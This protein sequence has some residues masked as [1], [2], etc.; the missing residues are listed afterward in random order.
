MSPRRKKTRWCSCPFEDFRGEIFKPRATPMSELEIVTLYQ[1]ELEAVKLC[2][3][4]GLTQEEAG[5][6]MGVSRGTVQRLI[7]TAH[8][9]IADAIVNQKALTFK[10]Y[11]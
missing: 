5:K 11:K 8:R 6:R 2:D 3:L 9:K 10:D 4:E 1:D 7:T